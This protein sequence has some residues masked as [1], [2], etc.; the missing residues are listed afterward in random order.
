MVR[1][2]SCILHWVASEAEVDTALKNV[3]DRFRWRSTAL[4][5]NGRMRDVIHTDNLSNPQTGRSHHEEA[6]TF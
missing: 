5:D 2:A 3:N 4:N 1:H 6:K